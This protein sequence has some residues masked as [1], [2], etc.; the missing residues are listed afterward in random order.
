MGQTQSRRASESDSA[1]EKRPA[2]CPV[3][4]NYETPLHEPEGQTPRTIVKP[5]ELVKRDPDTAIR[6]MLPMAHQ[7]MSQLP[8]R[9]EA[10]CLV[11]GTCSNESGPDG[12]LASS[13]RDLCAAMKRIYRYLC[14]PRRASERNLPFSGSDFA[15][16]MG[17]LALKVES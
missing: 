2:Q 14:N 5:C 7:K 1:I 9:I 3:R 17:I 16:A 8:F 10:V 11:L 6:R 12:G 15:E 13:V 4:R